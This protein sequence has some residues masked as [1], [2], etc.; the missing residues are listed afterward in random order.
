MAKKTWIQKRDEHAY[1]AERKMTSK[2]M[3]YIS[4]PK[5]I[6]E[7]I[8]EIPKGKLITT[9]QIVERL[10]SKHKVDFTCPLTTGIFISILANAAKEEMDSGKKK[11][12]PFWRVIKPNGEIYDV[13]MRVPSRQEDLLEIEGYKF[14]KKYKLPRVIDF[15]KYL[16]AD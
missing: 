5:E 13:H 6:N 10:T 3:M 11:I 16:V 14:S 2:G 12:V 9:K 4:T 8:V 7:I 1:P 15:E